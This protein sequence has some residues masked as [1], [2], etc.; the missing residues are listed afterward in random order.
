M[1]ATAARRARGG[2]TEAHVRRLFWRAGF[3][4]TP[5]EARTWARRGKA[6]T[7]AWILDGGAG[8]VLR[9]PEPRVDGRR[10]DP[11]NEWGHDMLWWLDRMVRSQRPLVEKLTLFWHDHFATT[12]QDTPLML[13]QNRMLRARA[14]GS[15]RV[16]LGDVMRDPAMQMFLSLADSDKEHPNENFARELFELFALGRGYTERDIRQAARALTGFES[17]WKNDRFDRI[18]FTPDRHDRGVKQIFGQRGR[19]TP[20]DVLDLA[21]AHPRHAPFLVTKLWHW[22]IVPEPSRATV[23]SLTSRYRRS[24]GAIKP[25]VAAIL[26]H[27][28]L[29]ADLGAP[30]MVKSPVVFM[31]GALRVTRTPIRHDSPTWMLQAAGQLLFRP[32]S[33]AGWDGGPAWMSSNAMRVRYEI[34][35]FLL[36][37]GRGVWIED[38]KG[39]PDLTPAA[40]LEQALEA[41]GRPW[42]SASTRTT[43][44]TMCRRAMAG[45]PRDPERRRERVERATMLQR[46]LRHLL[47]TGPDAQVH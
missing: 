43:L 14:L 13:A 16:L 45:A 21:V 17:K 25:V 27:P 30:D 22:F 19:F 32:P 18:V 4:A 26:A 41:T 1:S 31:A 46:A 29:Y 9:G 5:A 12:D 34:G 28:A 20:D 6:A 10:L 23:R 38:G 7:L 35:N 44:L 11:V 24:G 8:P 15:F 36:E 42:I 47:L 39:D 2:W 33:V 40:A 3:G 37:R